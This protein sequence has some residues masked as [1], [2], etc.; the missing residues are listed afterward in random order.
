MVLRSRRDYLEAVRLR[1]RCSGKKD[2]SV[3]L[4]EFCAI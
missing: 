4:D 1:Y 2:K 3:I